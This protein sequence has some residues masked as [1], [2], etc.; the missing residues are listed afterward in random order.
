MR[1]ITQIKIETQETF[2][3]YLRD[4]FEEPQTFKDYL[5]FVLGQLYDEGHRVTDIRLNEHCTQ[6][7]IVYQMT[8]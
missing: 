8:L 5:N 6:C 1:S 3:Y 2:E 4:F 7:I